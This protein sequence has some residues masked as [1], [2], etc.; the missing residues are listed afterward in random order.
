MIEPGDLLASG[1]AADV[2]DQ[3]DGTVLRRY[4]TE[5]DCEPEARLMSWLHGQGFPVP[6][7]YQA[8]ERD[9]V[10]ERVSG[11]TMLEDLERRPWLVFGHVRTLSELQK[12]LN[13]MR[14]PEWV[15]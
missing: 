9:I 8:T 1:R 14:A 6:I 13:E 10:M 12:K 15:R 7:V 5:Y 11:L 2:F 4:R 3:G